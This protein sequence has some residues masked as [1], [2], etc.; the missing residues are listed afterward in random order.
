MK[1]GIFE[2]QQRITQADSDPRL[3]IAALIINA[4]RQKNPQLVG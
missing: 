2:A 1:M 4:L 3:Q